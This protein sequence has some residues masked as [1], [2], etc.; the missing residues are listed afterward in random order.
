M[1]EE[2]VDTCPHCGSE[3][4]LHEGE[5]ATRQINAAEERENDADLRKA[6]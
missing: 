1:N 4:E 2:T 5:P 6:S 3:N